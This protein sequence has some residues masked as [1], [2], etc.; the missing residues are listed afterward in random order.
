MAARS[1]LRECLDFR[2]RI[3]VGISVQCVP[4]LDAGADG[5]GAPTGGRQPVPR[6]H[7]ASD[8]VFVRKVEK[9]QVAEKGEALIEVFLGSGNVAPG[10]C[11]LSISGHLVVRPIYR[12][13][14]SLQ[15]RLD[16]DLSRL[17]S[18]SLAPEL[19][20]VLMREDGERH[21]YSG[22]A[23]NSLQPARCSGPIDNHGS[24]PTLTTY[25]RVWSPL[26]K[27]LIDGASA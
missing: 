27:P 18:V 5:I 8:K 21:P 24:P 23:P 19:S 13:S 10:E 12:F 2:Q 14:A 15:H 22:Q 17:S 1:E 26:R 16:G 6:A 25:G 20:T 3:L 9:R 11:D 7:D 4:A